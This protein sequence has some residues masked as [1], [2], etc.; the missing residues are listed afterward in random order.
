MAGPAASFG[1]GE[2]ANIIGM[3]GVGIAPVADEEGFEEAGS[4]LGEMTGLRFAKKFGEALMSSE[5]MIF[6]VG[7]G[8][9]ESFNSGI[10]DFLD[11]NGVDIRE[12]F[13]GLEGFMAPLGA[14]IDG[15]VGKIPLIGGAIS[16]VYG[17]FTQLTGVTTEYLGMIGDLGEKW[18]GVT[19]ILLGAGAEL[20][21]IDTLM[22]NVQNMMAEG[23]IEREEDI[24]QLGKVQ[25]RLGLAGQALEKFTKTYSEANE[26]FDR[27]LNLET[28]T[29]LM[30]QFHVSGQ[31]AA[32]TLTVMTN[33]MRGVGGDPNNLLAVLKNLGPMFE[34]F[35]YSLP[36]MTQIFSEFTLGGERVERL[37]YAITGLM[38]NILDSVESGA[39]QDLQSG[40]TATLDVANQFL[41]LGTQEGD[42]KALR[43]M[44]TMAG[45]R[46]G[47]T[48][49]KA[50]QDGILK[51]SEAMDAMFNGGVDPKMNRALQEGIDK[52]TSLNEVLT[53]LERQMEAAFRPSSVAFASVLSDIGN[54]AI[55]WMAS[56]QLQIATWAADITETAIKMF[57]K[58]VE[59]FGN[60]IDII[61][62]P[63]EV[64]KDMVAV[65]FM[66]VLGTL[67]LVARAADSLFSTDATQALVESL[68]TAIQATKELYDL[69][70]Y[71]M[72]LGTSARQFADEIRG[73]V[74]PFRD[75]VDGETSKLAIQKSFQILDGEGGRPYSAV[76]ANP[77]GTF[78]W[79]IE[80]K[81]AQQQIIDNLK[82]LGI[83]T[84]D[85]KTFRADNKESALLLQKYFEY[86]SGGK[87]MA[88]V[89]PD[90]KPLLVDL[91]EGKGVPALEP[92]YKVPAT[93]DVLDP[94]GDGRNGLDGLDEM[95]DSMPLYDIPEGD[96]VIAPASF[97]PSPDQPKMFG[98]DWFPD[99]VRPDAWT[100]GSDGVMQIAAT[101]EPDE[102][103]RTQSVSDLLDSMGVPFDLQGSDGIT[104]PV[105]YQSTGGANFSFAGMGG[106]IPGMGALNPNNVDMTGLQPQSMAAL[107]AIQAKF[108]DA[109]LTSAKLGRE[110]DPYEWH[111]DGR[112]LD[113]NVPGW[114][115]AEGVARGNAMV[116][117][118]EANKEMLGVAGTLWQVKDHFNH[119]H[120]SIK[121]GMSPLLQMGGMPSGGATPA[122]FNVG[123]VAGGGGGGG[124]QAIAN[125]ILQAATARGYS[126]DE[127][128]AILAYAIGESSLNPA[129]N[130]KVQRTSGDVGPDSEHVVLGLFQQKPGFARDGG[131]DP[132]MRTDP[133][134]N[135]FAYLNMLERYRNLPID[136]ALPATS[137]GGPLA[138]GSAAQPWGPLLAQAQ[139]LAGGAVRR[140]VNLLSSESPMGDLEK[141]QKALLR[142]AFQG[143]GGPSMTVGG[144]LSGPSQASVSGADEPSLWEQLTG[145]GSFVGP[146]DFGDGNIVDRLSNL[147]SKVF[148]GSFYLNKLGIDTGTD[149]W[150]KKF[151]IPV[152]NQMKG[153]MNALMEGLKGNIN[154]LDDFVSQFSDEKAN[155]SSEELTD[156]FALPDI[157]QLGR[158][159]GDEEQ[160]AGERAAAAAAI[161]LMWSRGGG[162]RRNEF[163]PDGPGVVPDSV[164]VGDGSPFTAPSPADLSPTGVIPKPEDVP[165]PSISDRVAVEQQKLDDAL[166]TLAKQPAGAREQMTVLQQ[167]ADDAAQNLRDLYAE[168]RAARAELEAP[169]GVIAPEDVGQLAPD[170][171]NLIDLQ[172]PRSS[173]PPPPAVRSDVVRGEIRQRLEA[174]QKEAD[175]ALANWKKKYDERKDGEA[176]LEALAYYKS[177]AFAVDSL[178]KAAKVGMVAVPFS[179]A[180]GGLY[181][182]MSDRFDGSVLAE[183][184]P[185]DPDEQGDFEKYQEEQAKR[186]AV[187]E[188]LIDNPS[189]VIPRV[190]D[191]PSPIL[192]PPHDAPYPGSSA[193]PPSSPPPPS[194]ASGASGPSGAPM[195]PA[196]ASGASGASGAAKPPAAPPTA[197]PA[198]TEPVGGAA[199]LVYVADAGGWVD[200]AGNVF[201][202]KDGKSP[203]GKTWKGPGTTASAPA[204][205]APAVPAPAAPPPAAAPGAPPVPAPSSVPVPAN[206]APGGLPSLGTGPL[207]GP[208]QLDAPIQTPYGP[209]SS[210]NPYTNLPPGLTPEQYLDYTKGTEQ[211]YLDKSRRLEDAAA[212]DKEIADTQK[213]LAAAEK[214][215][216]EGRVKELYD[217]FLIEKENK[218]TPEAAAIYAD[219]MKPLIEDYEK[220]LAKV[221]KW[222]DKLAGLEEKD[223]D[224]DAQDKIDALEP[225]PKP[226]KGDK[227]NTDPDENAQQLGQGLVTG[228][229][230]AFGLDGSV[231]E[232]FQD[233]G[234]TKLVAGGINYLSGIAAA[235]AE[236][237]YAG[238]AGG[239]VG[240]GGAGGG[241]LLP[242]LAGGAL[243]G[244]L[245][246]ASVPALDG[247]AARSS[248]V[249]GQPKPATPAD[250]N[251]HAGGPSVAPAGFTFNL[252]QQ[253]LLGNRETVGQAADEIVPAAMT[254]DRAAGVGAGVFSF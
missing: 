61:K 96:R 246:G 40:L 163:S 156:F 249:A 49:F 176:T 170:S 213:G 159:A 13:S 228:I 46:G 10:Q 93:G 85:L 127:A 193:A 138:G 103:P 28:I 60:A 247:M 105:S 33:L 188:D 25:S 78:S 15:T 195:P 224:R 126:K 205:S 83:H 199:G 106:G 232:N 192:P 37:S 79:A 222:R 191:L 208:P 86:L 5:R 29:G 30:N 118:I 143:G 253:S 128:T 8:L 11:G 44:Q 34:N 245:P 38:K 147:S 182:G 70:I 41:A 9:A 73:L 116:A 53:T 111:P 26:T 99:G 82:I 158:I 227:S 187:L 59:S 229:L 115:T 220:E 122:A 47:Q 146:Q 66:P 42:D 216:A 185:D 226:P 148:S 181:A 230:E 221:Q 149:G 231:F 89:G 197:A 32:Q 88:V 108:P 194:G 141:L 65:A 24:F 57:A 3:M 97:A 90:G 252:N 157:A 36:Q 150:Q 234:A 107:A 14:A 189:P 62:V 152:L 102:S 100:I 129:A 171:G 130:G 18:Q 87:P 92:T 219:K 200:G 211:Y 251:S 131:I 17:Q 55:S 63:L 52:T 48:L 238:G 125:M 69:D 104:I 74:D 151:N 214:T 169:S 12:V 72:P 134:S 190:E 109:N 153:G 19:R 95:R 136:Q 135:I 225:P 168:Q 35:G 133:A 183:E 137:G 198:P 31:D 172:L 7:S 81:A 240:G 113:L 71:K 175:D 20:E 101:L 244:L 140:D 186:R 50:L 201:S 165:V 16:D 21:N 80:N 139:A 207:P 223:S 43:W 233:W 84:Q 120:V 121:E 164:K 248:D 58:I 173:T 237:G 202:D 236:A 210:Y 6:D 94:S 144:A 1:A 124:K 39:V 180:A 142:S 166:A 27:T 112:G 218:P 167:Q 179:L 184:L 174:A 76:Q 217:Q 204:A 145:P 45:P 239:P 209:T 212:R 22:G 162:L 2:A 254:R 178:I 155:W 235:G 64:I 196:P 250:P 154:S 98:E 114:Q 242:G 110:G 132:S 206:T 56:N 23:F 54:G 215:F 4:S 117:W 160:V 241:G 51:S 161:G 77:D 119:I 177:K 243:G 67:E 68:G 91:S 123:S 75:L 203:T